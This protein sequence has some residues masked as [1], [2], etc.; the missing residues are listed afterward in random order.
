MLLRSVPGLY[1]RAA[2]LPQARCGGPSQGPNFALLLREAARR[3]QG[4]GM[5]QHAELRQDMGVARADTA[6]AR[7]VLAV[8]VVALAPEGQM[9]PETLARLRMVAATAPALAGF[10]P[11]AVE[12]MAVLTLR[13]IALRGP[14]RVL[15]DL[16]GQFTRHL[17]ETALTLAVRAAHVDGRI[18]PRRAD[19]LGGIAA[20]F[21]V[22]PAK[23]ADIRDVVAIL[24][25]AG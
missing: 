24:E 5:G 1:A 10:G 16:Q 21:G 4:I 17:A 11:A 7:A 2:P 15:T 3:R 20:W 14:D 13:G 22:P 9:P 18:A 19:V 23:L 25:G 6:R 8:M 12:E